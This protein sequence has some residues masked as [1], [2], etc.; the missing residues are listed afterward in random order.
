MSFH[1]GPKLVGEVEELI[2]MDNRKCGCLLYLP[3]IIALSFFIFP[4]FF[5]ATEFIR[6]AGWRMAA[7]NFVGLISVL[8]SYK[9]DKFGEY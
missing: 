7:V 5:F 6:M 8:F 4:T 9:A 3:Y 2:E 1:E